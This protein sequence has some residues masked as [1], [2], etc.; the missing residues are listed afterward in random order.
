MNDTKI[1]SK[2]K[3]RLAHFMGKVFTHFSKPAK[4]FIEECIYGIQASGDTKLSSIVRA[5]DNDTR[6]IYTEKRL[7]RNMDDETLEASVAEAVLRDG[8]RSVKGDTLLLVDPTE[9]RKEFSY[10]ME[11]VT[12]V[13]DASRSSKEG[14]DVLVN[15]YHGCMVA[16]CRPGGRKTVPL[17]LKLWSSRSPGF[18]GEN[19]EVLKIVR[20]VHA[21]TGGKGTVV[22]DRG[23][24]RH[25]P[26]RTASGARSPASESGCARRR[27]AAPCRAR[28]TSTCPTAE[29]RLV[30]CGL[31]SVG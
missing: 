6:P 20:A 17:A 12:R 21:A 8:A 31:L 27:I 22:Y 28:G 2:A 13:R 14:R 26:S 15:G 19:D 25:T 24:E 9:I 5:I 30:A 3:A 10:K 18:R 23:G 7:S 29:M 1:A 11:F 4:K 16:A